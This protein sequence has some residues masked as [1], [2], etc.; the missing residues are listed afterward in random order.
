MSRHYDVQIKN[1]DRLKGRLMQ[2]HRNAHQGETPLQDLLNKKSAY[3]YDSPEWERLTSRS[4]AIVN[5]Y[6]S[7]LFDNIQANLTRWMLYYTNKNNKV[8]YVTK[9]QRLP[10]YI[11]DNGNFNGNHFWIPAKGI[12]R[13]R[14]KGPQP[15][16]STPSTG[17]GM[18]S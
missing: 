12:K 8:V 2:I 6:A 17:V 3:I 10:K 14:N 15:F 1:M 11:R 13:D 18:K 16:G 9:W 7:A 5:G 4:Q